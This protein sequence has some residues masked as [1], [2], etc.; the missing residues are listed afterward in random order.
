MGILRVAVPSLRN[1]L[2]RAAVV[3]ATVYGG[4]SLAARAVMQY[5]PNLI[6]TAQD[7]APARVKDLAVR[8]FSHLPVLDTGLKRV[9]A[10][11]LGILALAT[12]A[13][14][15]IARNSLL[16]RLKIAL[17]KP[18]E[19]LRHAAV[20]QFIVNADSNGVDWK[21]LTERL[22]PEQSTSLKDSAL[23]LVIKNEA[24][25]TESARVFPTEELAQALADFSAIEVINAIDAYIK[26]EDRAG[27]SFIDFFMHSQLLKSMNDQSPETN[28]KLYPLICL[29]FKSHEDELPTT[30]ARGRTFE[31]VMRTFT[32]DA[33]GSIADVDKKLMDVLL[34]V[35]QQGSHPIGQALIADELGEE[36][37][38]AL[39]ADAEMWLKTLECALQL[40]KPMHFSKFTQDTGLAETISDNF[41][42]YKARLCAHL[43][44]TEAWRVLEAIIGPSEESQ[45][46]NI[47]EAQ[48]KIKAEFANPK[49][50]IDPPVL[51]GYALYHVTPEDQEVSFKLNAD[52]ATAFPEAVVHLVQSAPKGFYSGDFR[53]L[54]SQ[55]S[56]YQKDTLSR[57]RSAL[58][59][60]KLPSNIKGLPQWPLFHKLCWDLNSGAMK[61]FIQFFD[62]RIPSDIYDA[63]VEVP[64][65]HGEGKGSTSSNR[66][67]L[68][69]AV[70]KWIHRGDKRTEATKCLRV[71]IAA[72]PDAF[73][74]ALNIF[75]NEEFRN[76]FE[77]LIEDEYRTD[78]MRYQAIQTYAPVQIYMLQS[79]AIE[80][81]RIEEPLKFE[82]FTVEES[83][84][85]LS[86]D[87]WRELA[88]AQLMQ[89]RAAY[90]KLFESASRDL[91]KSPR[92]TSS[93]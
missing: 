28:Q 26:L 12:L 32:E 21:E 10:H 40:F 16:H 39:K 78:H 25:D 8:A 72:A 68:M 41:T 90:M 2:P 31:L 93:V 88:P 48:S 81:K 49:G 69:V 30:E 51:L 79:V 57:C 13:C 58:L 11:G 22:T 46:W 9:A 50:A 86:V 54:A 87:S 70:Q 83:V 20:R 7:A 45:E 23:N 52:I 76:L 82:E 27:V 5:A 17:G 92:R 19:D 66:P 14:L 59:K 91:G 67:P 15:Y 71:L 75:D 65:E 35:R 63:Q 42:N 36:N 53:T 24:S 6:Q 38:Q 4:L 34:R 73:R 64:R 89:A 55:L 37:A 3:S 80:T 1:T 47:A 33:T 56:T 60:A 62:G 29:Y 43:F 44:N 84:D 85:A 18:A 61:A 74:L 77:S